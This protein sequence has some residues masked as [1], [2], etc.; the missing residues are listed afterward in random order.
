MMRDVW[1]CHDLSGNLVSVTKLQQAALEIIFRKD[2]VLIKK[3]A[4]TVLTSQLVGNLFIAK[5]KIA[6][7]AMMMHRRMGHSSKYLVSEICET[8]LKS[9]QTRL[10]FHKIPEEV[11]P[12]GYWRWF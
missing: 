1:V 9:K 6:A 10:P 8:C 11:K 3:G 4:K 12:K 2:Q 7:E 5:M